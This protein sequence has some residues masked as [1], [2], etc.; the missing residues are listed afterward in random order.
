MTRRTQRKAMERWEA[1]TR[2]WAFETARDLALSV[3]RGDPLPARPY[4]LGVVLGPQETAWVECPALLNVGFAPRTTGTPGQSYCSPWP[5]T[6]ERIIGR[7]A[8]DRLDG[9]RWDSVVGCRLQL[10]E[11]SSWLCLELDGDPLL[12]WSGPGV[13]P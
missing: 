7:L 2:R 5:V 10:A 12:T 6:S 3:Y 9:Y 11:V 1:D 8:D 4:A 13:A